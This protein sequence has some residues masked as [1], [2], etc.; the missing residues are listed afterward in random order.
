[1]PI[2]TE[3]FPSDAEFRRRKIAL[4]RAGYREM[5][6]AAELEPFTYREAGGM[7]LA[8]L[9]GERAAFSEDTADSAAAARQCALVEFRAF[10]RQ[11]AVMA[12]D[13]ARAVA[14]FE[15]CDDDALM[16]AGRSLSWAVSNAATTHLDA[17][18]LLAE[19]RESELV[20][21]ALAR[22][23]RDASPERVRNDA[24]KAEAAKSAVPAK[25]K[26]VRH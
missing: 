16:S 21:S 19:A 3:T 26:S 24:R 5:L 2:E 18:R 6:P 25:K 10:A 14:R 4:W 8:V 23:V 11:V 12:E 1:M 9:R 15:D 20:L 13:A 22:V 17:A 7:S